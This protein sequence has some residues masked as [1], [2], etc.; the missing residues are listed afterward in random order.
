MKEN[1]K[2][3]MINRIQTERFWKARG[4]MEAMREHDKVMEALTR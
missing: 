3:D 4:G 2:Q 1:S